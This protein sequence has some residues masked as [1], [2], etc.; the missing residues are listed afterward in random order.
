[1]LLMKLTGNCVIAQSG[2]PTA[3]INASLCGVIQKAMQTEEIT[4]IYGSLNGILGI[5]NNNLIDLSK[6]DPFEIELLKTTPSSILGSCR[7]KLKPPG[8]SE[9]YQKILNTFKTHNIRYFFYIGGNDSMDTADKLNKFIN[10]SGH[11]IRI[12]GI[13]KTIDN[14]LVGTDHCPG[15]GSAAKY[16]STTVSEIYRD[17]VVYPTS[18]IT[19]VEIMGRN[20]GWLTASSALANL[21]GQGPDLIY[22]PEAP[23]SLD[24]FHNDVASIHKEK[25][26]VLICASEG[27]RD[28]NGSYIAQLET[29]QSHDAF[30][31]AQLGGVGNVLKALISDIDKRIKVIE[32]GIM[33]RSAAHI[34]S[35]TDIDEALKAG[36]HALASAIEGKSGFMVSLVRK[37]ENS[38]QCSYGL[39][40]L[41]SVANHEHKIPINWINEKANGVTK[42][43]VEYIKPLI[44][45]K[46]EIFEDDNGLIRFAKLNKFLI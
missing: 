29:A 1:M 45:G 25:G 15:F 7:Y 26:K 19:I 14:D 23:F 12:I 31:H 8:E 9:D 39:T 21:S 2:G 5:I 22:L 10:D 44:K 35:A 16:I 4:A 42:E 46:N 6:E 33:Q 32:L 41:S 34:A 40:P 28:S 38:Y 30:G 17:T 18:Q 37:Y 27:I 20:A 3:V 43:I 36:E 24:K 11:D 13:P